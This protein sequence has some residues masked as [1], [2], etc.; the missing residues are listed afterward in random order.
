MKTLVDNYLNFS[1]EFVQ[2]NKEK[3]NECDIEI[4]SD[5]LDNEI[6][7][8]KFYV[9]YVE[10]NNP[11]IVLCGINPGRFGAGK[12]GVSFLDFQSLQKILPN[13][14]RN[15][16]EK[17]GSF[18]YGVIEEIG[19][20]KFYK[21]VYVTNLSCVGFQNLKTKKN[22]NYYQ[23]CSKIQYE[24]FDNFIKEMN[25]IKP[26]IIIPLSQWVNWDLDNL[27][28]ENRLDFEIGKRLNHPAYSKVTKESYIDFLNNY[29][30]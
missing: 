25:I 22:M 9:K 21:N 17:S 14:S 27:K 11:K 4:L 23:I 15:D 19:V 28:K 16:H 7:I 12:T 5:F 6:N 20:D 18:F 13:I 30:K 24:L 2:Q 8:R 26:D 29:I 1:R 3:L 10:N